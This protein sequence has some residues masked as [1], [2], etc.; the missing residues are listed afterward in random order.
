MCA[1]LTLVLLTC[2]F[3]GCGNLSG[4]KPGEPRQQTF[5]RDIAGVTDDEIGAIE[6]LREKF[7]YFIY[8]MLPSTEMFIDLRNG[9]MNGYSAL[10]CDWL[11]ELFGIE[12]RPALYEWGDLLA[13]MESDK[14]GF[15]GELTPSNERRKIYFMTDPIAVR[16]VKSF[17]L[18]GSEPISE[19]ESMRPVRYV[20][21][22]GAT[23][24]TDVTSLLQ[25]KIEIIFVNDYE[26]AYEKLKTGEGD[27][28]FAENNVEAAFDQYIDVI[29]ADY[30]PLIY[31]PVSLTT[32]NPALAPVIS[33]VQKALQGDDL[34]YL[35]EL[36]QHGYNEYLKHKLYSRL[37]EEERKYM[38]NHPVVLFAAEYENYPMSF[39]N[40]QEKAW[41]GIVFDVLREIEKFT[42]LSFKLVNNPNTEWPEIL[43]MLNNG[44]VSF[45]S[46]L[47]RTPEREGNYIWPSTVLLTDYY[48]LISK[49]EHPNIS[50]NE[51]LYVKVGVPRNTA[52]YEVFDTWFPNHRNTVMYEGSDIAFNA[53]ARGEVDMT[54]ASMYKLLALTNFREETGYKANVVFD[55]YAESTLG[56]NV[57]DALLCSIV[58]KTLSMIDT[59]G[60]ADQWTRKT[61]DYRIRL[62]RA[63][64]PW[65]SGATALLVILLF[66][67][68]IY[69]RN[70]NESKR[71]EELV[72]IRTAEL[73]QRTNEMESHNKLRVIINNVAVLLLESD[74]LDYSN[75]MYQGMEMVGKCL[76]VDRVI[77][78]Q[79]VHSDDGKIFHKQ[80]CLWTGENVSGEGL[81]EMHQEELPNWIIPVSQGVIINGPISEQPEEEQ[82]H[83]MLRKIESI[84]IIPIFLENEFWGLISFD[85]CNKQ[86][87]FRDEV[88]QLL[89]SWGLLV[90]GSIQRG[91]IAL[92]M[93]NT[94]NK[95]EAVTKNY[96]GVIWSV[97]ANGIITTF[98]GQYLKTMGLDSSFI[99]GKALSNVRLN[100]RHFSIIEYVEKTLHDGPQ[101][102]IGESDGGIFHSYTTPL[103]DNEN[104][105][106]GVVGSTDDVTETIRMNQE[107]EAA[108]RAKSI[109]LANM[110]HEIRTPMNAII[111]M[112]SIGIGA[113]DMDRMIYCFKKIEEASK[114]LLGIIND[115]L[116][117]SK[118]EA[119]KFELSPT[120]FNFER[121]LHQVVNVINF[122]ADEKQQKFS[123]H[124]DDDIPEYLFADNQ[125]I[126]QIITNLLSNAVKFT[127][128]E[129]L[130]GL[131]ARFI[132]EENGVCAIQIEVTDTGIGI[133]PD[134]H[135]RLFQSFQQADGDTARRFGGTGLGLA[136][137]K[138]IVEMMGGRIWIKSEPGAGSTFSFTVKAKRGAKKRLTY[139]DSSVNWK[140]LRILVVDDAPDILSF[141]DETLQKFG[142]TCHTAESGRDALRL[143]DEAG[144][145]NIYFI[146]WKMPEMDGIELARKLKTDAS[147]G[148]RSVVIMISAAELSEVESE[149]KAA[150]VDKFLSKPLFPSD[151]V[152][153]INECLGLNRQMMEETQAD[154]NGIFADRCIL[155]AEDVE[156]NREIVV[157]LL[158][159]TEINIECAENGMEAFNMFKAAPERYDMVFMDV[160]MPEMDGYDATR[161]IR[162]LDIPKAG[163]IPIIA[164]TANVFREDVEKCLGAGMNGH[165]GKPLNLDD[166][167][168][169]IQRHLP[170]RAVSDGGS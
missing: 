141:F 134:Q 123:I 160:Q 112:S 118:I 99:E 91:N 93:K 80:I 23:T 163:T 30:L 122:R 140:N 162:A 67:L 65:I 17:R 73:N 169:Q 126:A 170:K 25:K 20:F 42:D 6:A 95:L 108:S 27:I 149:A 109:F 44:D 64:I 46:E 79:N 76:E 52:Y 43:E 154:I 130:I 3:S 71:L 18:A 1:A 98:N 129:G 110:S 72:Q 39:Y 5:Y 128:N 148:V 114:H 133:S 41:Q 47:I 15:T 32:H 102:W 115:I 156:I 62:T 121:M 137:S 38:A 146:D 132:G 48:A 161:S 57:D 12:F 136:I 105:I 152:D 135:E 168:A 13:G 56:F 90:V 9:E 165:V 97:D 164:M 88:V 157:A 66:L 11:T 26:S 143:V 60:I 92:E 2:V 139:L 53:L 86:R 116:D 77:V 153:I 138:N 150:G 106:I 55:R 69:Y 101:D 167:L 33:V 84:L 49:S 145:Y 63:Q 54:M 107:L 31:S 81:M 45:V 4:E 82:A 28:F 119:G 124:I 117:M 94:L 85:D 21:L 155:L 166:V 104:R 50:I 111:G 103:Y 22:E 19:I 142:L 16:T 37:S 35:T 131:A 68:I 125:R 147:A 120:E 58:D 40:T 87:V 14:I 89:R 36:Y 158:E 113:S 100:N 78:W 61:Y 96:K 7:D 10:F 34:H 75:A 59:K 159:P 8:G 127:P 74:T 83:L 70:R 151:I 51:I 24:I 29:A 144:H